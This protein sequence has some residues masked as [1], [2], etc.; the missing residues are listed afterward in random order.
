MYVPHRV[1][2]R[3]D[4]NVVYRV[5]RRGLYIA[6]LR[7]MCAC[8]FVALLCTYISNGVFGNGLWTEL[9]TTFLVTNILIYTKPLIPFYGRSV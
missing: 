2:L 1:N 4:T 8:P 6:L 7:S 5:P 9:G 3:L